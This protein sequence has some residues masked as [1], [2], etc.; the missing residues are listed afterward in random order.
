MIS[1]VGFRGS[2]LVRQR[3][4]ADSP[5]TVSEF[6]ICVKVGIIGRLYGWND[7]SAAL[8]ASAAR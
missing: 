7:A 1:N 3:P 6:P 4:T 2:E 8:L 5:L